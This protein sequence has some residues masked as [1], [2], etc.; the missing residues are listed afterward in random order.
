MRRT[1]LFVC[2]HN[3]GRSQMAEAYVNS[4]FPDRFQAF[5]AGTEPTELN[6]AVA[7]V[8]AEEG[9]D[10]SGHRAKDVSEF[11]GREFDCV[12]TVCDRAQESCPYFPGGGRRI[13]RGFAD[14][15]RCSGGEEEVL[16]CVRLIR[17]AVREWLLGPWWEP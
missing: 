16:S 13:H 8:M 10:L 9:I 1:V 5:S 7:A 2:T 6:R 3:S 17:D 15:S 11:A 12:V 4:L 14:P